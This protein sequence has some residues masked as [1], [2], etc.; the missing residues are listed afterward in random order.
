MS[1]RA[2]FNPLA[3]RSPSKSIALVDACTKRHDMRT[4]CRTPDKICVSP[5]QGAEG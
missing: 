4:E 3:M 5:V 1:D 2:G